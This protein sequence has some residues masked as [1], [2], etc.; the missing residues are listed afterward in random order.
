[1][2]ITYKINQAITFSSIPDKTLGSSAF[3]VSGTA[4][5]GLAVTFS[6]GTTSV[7]T[8]SGTTVTLVSSGTCT[9]RANQSGDSTYNA[10]SQ[11]QQSFTVSPSLTI[12]TPAGF[13]DGFVPVS[14]SLTVQATGGKAPLTFSVASGAL[15]AGLSLNSST[16]AISGVPTAATSST[17][18]IS[19]TDAN[20][21]S[22]TTSEFSIRVRGMALEDRAWDKNGTAQSFAY[23]TSNVIPATGDWTFETW[24]YVEQADLNGGNFVGLFSQM[25]NSDGTDNRAS[26]WLY[27]GGLHYATDGVS[28]G[29]I[30]NI[31]FQAGGW[32]HVAMARA[33]S[34]ARI[35]VDG[36]MVANQSSSWA[37]LGSYFSVGG[38]RQTG[39]N[40]VS[41]QIDQVKVWNG[42][43]DETDIRESMHSYSSSGVSTTANLRAHYDFNEWDQNRVIDRSGLG[44]HLQ[45]NTAVTGGYLESDFTSSKIIQTGTAFGQ[46]TYVKFNR[47][48]LTA[49]GGWQPPQGVSRVK[50][51]VVAGGGGGGDSST[52]KTGGRGG[53]G[54]LFYS[55]E[56]LLSGGVGVQVGLGGA[57]STATT[58]GAQGGDSFLGPLKVGGGGG[59]SGMSNTTTGAGNGGG[60]SDY[61]VGGNGGGTEGGDATLAN[62]GSGGLYSTTGISY[63]GKT[64]LGRQG[65]SGGIRV[66]SGSG[67][68]GG[69][70]VEGLRTISIDGSSTVYAKPGTYRAWS[71]TQNT[72]RPQT[73]GSG[74][75]ADYTYGGAEGSDTPSGGS[76][77]SGVVILSYGP[78]LAVSTSPTFAR[79]GTPFSSSI[80]VQLTELDGSLFSSTSPVTV[81]ASA[82]VLTLNGATLTQSY[83]VNAV[84]GLATFTGLGFASSVASAQTLTFTSDAFVGATLTVTPSYYPGAV[85]IKTSGTT[86]GSFA[87]GE[88][89][90]STTSGTTVILASDLTNHMQSFSTVIS[91]S[92]SIKVVNGFTSTSSN[93]LTLK[94][95]T[96][97]E[98]AASQQ[99]KTH[100]GDVV[101]WSDSDNSSGGY[102]RLL[103]AATLCTTGGTCSTTET[104]GGD[105]VLGG[106]L[107][108]SA[109]PSRPGGTAKGSGSSATAGQVDTT[110]VQVGTVG[111]DNAGAKLYSAGGE[112]IVRGQ[113]GVSIGN[114][115]GA[116]IAVIGGS[117]ISSGQGKIYFFGETTYAGGSGDDGPIN[118][119]NNGG[120]VSFIS[121]S[122]AS[123]AILFEAKQ[124]NSAV[125]THG[126]WGSND[127]S[128]ITSSGGLILR[129][130]QITDDLDLNLD[131]AGKLVIEGYDQSLRDETL[132]TIYH[133]GFSSSDN[134]LTLLRNPSAIQ[135]GNSTNSNEVE[136]ETSLSVD[137]P[138]DVY[139]GKIDVLN[140]VTIR[141]TSQSAQI[142][143]KVSEWIDI[144]DGTNAST[145][146]LIQTNNGSII[147]WSDSD[148]NSS[149]SIYM[150]SHSELNSA[151]GEKS[152]TRSGGGRITLGGGNSGS[153]SGGHPNGY[154][155]DT[156]FTNTGASNYALFLTGTS[157]VYSGGGDITYR[158]RSDNNS[159][160]A[161]RVISGHKSWSGTGR[162]T[163]DS[164]HTGSLEGAML[165]GE[166]VSATSASPAISI[167][168]SRGSSAPALF[169]QDGSR[170]TVSSIATSG[171][172]ISISA[173]VASATTNGIEWN[174]V[175][176]LSA[177]GSIR[178]VT[179]GQLDWSDA[180]ARSIGAKASSDVLSS[181]AS[182]Q[183]TAQA[184]EDSTDNTSSKISTS[185]SVQINPYASNFNAD[186]E[187]EFSVEAD[188][189]TF[190]SLANVDSATNGVKVSRDVSTGGQITLAGN[191]VTLG[192]GADLTTANY[193]V[194]ITLKAKGWIDVVSNQS[195]ALAQTNDSDFSTIQT[196]HGD[197]TLWSDSDA[198]QEGLIWIGHNARLNS[199][200]GVYSYE[201]VSG[202]G[203]IY[204]AGGNADGSG[205]PSSF[206]WDKGSYGETSS[207][208]FG[209]GVGAHADLFTGG[210]ELVLRAAKKNA[211]G[212]AAFIF[213][214]KGEFITGTGRL[215]IDAQSS[216]AVEAMEFY[217]ENEA[218]ALFSSHSTAQP[219]IS[220]SA[221]IS[222]TSTQALRLYNKDS[223]NP[224]TIQSLASTGGG[225]S[226]ASTLG[227]TSTNIGS[228]LAA[229]NFLS[230]NGEIAF[231]S[232]ASMSIT[233]EAYVQHWGAK[234]DSS[235][236]NSVAD[237]NW[238]VN[239]LTGNANTATVSTSGDVS[240]QPFGSTFGDA[241]YLW[242][243]VSG[244]AS[245]TL[246]SDSLISTATYVVY[247]R[248]TININGPIEM[249][250]KSFSWAN[251][252]D[253]KT[254]GQGSK[255]LLKAR[256]DIYVPD[257]SGTADASHT[258]FQ[259]NKGDIVLWSDADGS[260]AGG[261]VF[262]NYVQLTSDGGAKSKLAVSGGGDIV[263]GG[264]TASDADGHPTGYTGLTALGF[265]DRAAQIGRYNGIYT[266]GGDFS[267]KAR[268]SSTFGLTQ[269]HSSEFFTGTG[270]ATF[271]AV[272]TNTGGSY[273]FAFIDA[274][275]WANEDGPLT[276][277]SHSSRSPAISITGSTAG[278]AQ[279]VRL[280][281]QGGA[282]TLTLASTATEGGGIQISGQ[283][284]SAGDIDIHLYRNQ[285]LSRNGA[286]TISAGVNKLT[287]DYGFAASAT[288]GSNALSNYV[289]T[290][291]A[292]ISFIADEWDFDDPGT[293]I[294]TT[295]DVSILPKTNNFF[296]SNATFGINT[297]GIRNLTI[298]KD[299]LSQD[300]LREISIT[301]NHTVSGNVR[302]YGG[303]VYPKGNFSA[304]GA[305]EILFKALSDIR[306][307]DAARNFTTQG[308]DITFWA[309][310]NA[311]SGG[312]IYVPGS[313]KFSSNGGDITLAGGLDD[314]ASDVLGARVS[315]DGR[316]DGYAV[317]RSGEI[318]NSG[319][320]FAA[321]SAQRSPSLLSGGGD[322]YL[323][324]KSSN[325]SN[326][327]RTG[328]FIVSGVI[329]AGSGQ[330]RMRGT[331]DS[332]SDSSYQRALLFGSGGSDISVLSS[333][334]AADA[335]QIHGDASGATGGYCVGIQS[336]DNQNLLVANEGSGGVHLIGDGCASDSTDNYTYTDGIALSDTS[337]LARSGLIRLE[338]TTRNSTTAA[339]G[340]YLNRRNQSGDNG[341]FI[342]ANNRTYSL[343]TGKSV[344][345]STSSSNVEFLVNSINGNSTP[346]STSGTVTIK[347]RTGYAFSHSPVLTNIDLAN[348]VTGFEIGHS[349]VGSTQN[350]V[351]VTLNKAYSISGQISVYAQNISVTADQQITSGVGGILLKATGRISTGTSVDLRTNGGDVVLWAD[352]DAS[353]AGSI[354]LEASNTMCSKWV[355]STCQS[356]GGGDIYL[357]G[358]AA[359]ADGNPQG[360]AKGFGTTGTS[361][362]GVSVGTCAGSTSN[363]NSVSLNSAGGAMHIRGSGTAQAT[364]TGIIPAGVVLCGGT[365]LTLGSGK[366]VIDSEFRGT[367]STYAWA[368]MSAP[369]G[370][371]AP[372][373][374]SAN[375][376]DDAVLISAYGSME[377]YVSNGLTYTNTNGGGMVL[378]I[379]SQFSGSSRKFN[380]SSS[381][382]LTI[383]P[384]GSSFKEEIQLAST[385]ENISTAASG[386]TVG[387]ATNTA[388]I[389][390]TS[391]YAIAGDYLFQTSSFTNTG[392]IKSTGS[393]SKIEI[394]ADQVSVSSELV[395]TNSGSIELR[396]KTANREIA[397]GSSV[398]GKLS[399]DS[400]TA[401]LLK[402]STLRIGS[403]QSGDI[404]LVANT[405]FANADSVTLRTAGDVSGVNG[406]VLTA[407][408][409]AIDAGGNVD[410][411]GGQAVIGNVAISA[412]SSVTY[413]SAVSYSPAVVDG[414][415]ALFGVGVAVS[416]T[417]SPAVQNRNAFLAV[418]FNPPPQ[419]V[420]TDT[421]SNTLDGN[422]RL[423][424]TYTVSAT[425][426][427]GTG[428]VVGL[429]ASRS[430]DV[431]SFNSLRVDSNPGTYSFT[432]NVDDGATGFSVSSID[433]T[434]M[435][436]D[437]SSLA[438]TA[439]DNTAPAGQA[440][441]SFTVEVQDSAGNPITAGTNANI[442]V[443]ASVS[444]TTAVLVSGNQ[445][446]AD[447]S[448]VANFDDLLITGSVSDAISISFFVEFTNNQS[449][450]TTVSSSVY[451]IEL[452]P[453]TP[454]QLVIDDSSQSV[455]NRSTFSQLVVSLLDAYGNQTENVSGNI[456]AA[457]GSGSGANLIGT[458]VSALAAGAGVSSK[459]TFSNLA[460]AGTAG[461]FRIDFTYSGA[462]V[463]SISHDVRLTAGAASSLVLTTP[464]SGAR[465]GIA[466]ETQPALQMQDVDGNLVAANVSVSAEVSGETVGG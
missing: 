230:T 266:G 272:S 190:G 255:I 15:P 246:G 453:G 440:S 466:F 298:G 66:D 342:G 136:L 332:S 276:I 58:T 32:H 176:L 99:V 23:T 337:V 225:L 459:A 28:Y 209:V 369:G 331:L 103:S 178:V 309:D 278:T 180:E 373:I 333:N 228:Y 253:L 242:Q 151:N 132:N 205:K 100:G 328:L 222:G 417:N 88:F 289:T 195:S 45:Y 341:V 458:T 327:S 80:A 320:M 234:A 390:V 24:L 358:G 290:S 296:G 115:L 206:A 275:G 375:S 334:G 323:A 39:Y 122:T 301:G 126:I 356:S 302:V 6:S 264:G 413:S 305:G 3:S 127:S 155:A 433:Y 367:G 57:G 181:A 284:A 41:G 344:N 9:I 434:V 51:L 109:N 137:G 251:N 446:R 430:S 214:S 134:E 98:V 164:I 257:G 378:A 426:T 40:E 85:E 161:A 408:N 445:V 404:E 409:L 350:T 287:L 260:G 150:G 235:V 262:G 435:A 139:A 130:N 216:V 2:T 46:Q 442:T 359:D 372:Q 133:C 412:S 47:S 38:T 91:A 271:E 423:A 432:V 374:S 421:Y 125:P 221:S 321:A 43:L 245:F 114:S 20:G 215:V 158:V 383:R 241:M 387:S 306:T 259:T 82:G 365:Q 194:S 431:Y 193:G 250:G 63:L 380:F 428:T 142:L 145:R 12:S 438:V 106:G 79:A 211:G 129:S 364:G 360:N 352:S 152:K 416:Q 368:F 207:T 54:G 96:F 229:V 397:I 308:G 17:V 108:D 314:G 381:G 154:V 116:G 382:Q 75:A 223:A 141:S 265:T 336:Y 325:V 105:I 233:N 26:L 347:S 403:M 455:A 448:G 143:F 196:N 44:N 399:I 338:G 177:A 140:N 10:A 203:D 27:N 107:A 249:Y 74:G 353:G 8:V 436:G 173:S 396:P 349:G 307:D 61:L 291:S 160:G 217:V 447:N 16:G 172:G 454:T 462:G 231:T 37:T 170:L 316:P 247:P 213:R 169:N 357:A 185:G 326:A 268:S 124:N 419:F 90:A 270:V 104:G 212:L 394:A 322:I 252:E 138:I 179:N 167:S 64:Y 149:G 14:Y 188:S 274:G 50:A 70:I 187:I 13:L 420:V 165:E 443:S 204:L 256:D 280:Y 237:V 67:G 465:A 22:R 201:A 464:A 93:N 197:I 146:N 238:R 451:S 355:S 243:D 343:S 363:D 329:D 69:S 312:L 232:N 463:S 371:T 92:G 72:A 429:T 318:Y 273:G 254:S 414:V 293:V 29:N 398:S 425:V 121:K 30:P 200:N 84:N 295:G 450:L 189:F 219:A 25:A 48:Y 288:I 36:V 175:D 148:G 53:A 269:Y 192:A 162:I 7:C 77:A 348:S 346:I 460:L 226:I 299:P 400:S 73:P 258:Y 87:N 33:G 62:V 393:G 263:L 279:A 18:S 102:I 1:M 101:L 424:A 362:A 388:S 113:M 335:I 444:G 153:D 267:L 199:D 239:V 286:I 304:T 95:T 60:G 418:T 78:Y 19:V 282:N 384:N 389:R 311:T 339:S 34:N 313:S 42:A 261:I 391:S 184:Y 128:S 437:P 401:S 410:L 422:N 191:S 366:L 86:G 361:S 168:A 340:V 156:G 182:V 248:S 441:F 144:R 294:N 406:A 218:G 297:N 227:S 198:N 354:Y 111:T 377:D 202:G 379:D 117:Q 310:S 147:L 159:A 112:I 370:V 405:N 392:S 427:Q 174:E 300:T 210:G 118:I 385:I 21:Y 407:Q 220:I 135:I 456:S 439:V 449:V 283:A 183:I 345:I 285:I 52:S 83:T 415:P 166:F 49:A 59:G 319:I 240:I 171:G 4:S 71:N 131:V 376:E 55:D 330:V 97:I 120:S 277:V 402:T 244:A 186:S 315:G 110:G 94:T 411:P 351:D 81:T 68:D 123:D 5:S 89:F 395:A 281:G 208:D 386:V 56:V 303:Y 35:F 324:G 461:D 119:G 157:Q 236:S 163:L 11:V 317:G 457:I 292:N 65:V 452:T 76:G 224:T 31:P